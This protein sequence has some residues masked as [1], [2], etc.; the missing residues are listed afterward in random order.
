MHGYKWP[1]NCTRTRT[2]E[3]A[4]DDDVVAAYDEFVSDPAKPV[5]YIRDIAIE[6]T[7]EHMVD[8]Q[9]FAW[10]RPDVLSYQTE[11]LATDVTIVG[12]VGVKL[13]VSVTGTDADFI[14]KLIDV[15][16]PDAPSP[17]PPGASPYHRS[18]AHINCR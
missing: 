2:A 8:D 15:F 1:I 5:P 16:S 9:R 6:M 10:T 14:V 7:E 18:C 11:V 4:R 12:P 13:T 3:Q 17:G